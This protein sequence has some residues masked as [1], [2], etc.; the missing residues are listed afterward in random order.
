MYEAETLM[1]FSLQWVCEGARQAEAGP[2]GPPPSA[3]IAASLSLAQPPRRGPGGGSRGGSGGDWAGRG[4]VSGPRPGPAPLR[5]RPGRTEE[6]GGS[7]RTARGA[8]L[9]QAPVRVSGAGSGDQN[10]TGGS[11]PTP[12][13]NTHLGPALAP[14]PP[15]ILIAEK[16]RGP[17]EARRGAG[18][19][20]LV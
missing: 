4:R 18:A 10:R 15:R 12:G 2:R 9:L 6:E 20:A 7:T 14:P 13:V 19:G 16:S 17:G 1:F 5:S 3:R 11:D 8:A